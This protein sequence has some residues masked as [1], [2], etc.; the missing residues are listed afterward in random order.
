[1]TRLLLIGALALL[2]WLGLERLTGRRRSWGA[3]A[4]RHP[5][6]AAAQARQLLRCER[7]GVHFPAEQAVGKSPVYCSD[8]CRTHRPE[9]RPAG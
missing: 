6:Q 3:R 8:D 9:P 5:R 4:G 1:M 2:F 7:C